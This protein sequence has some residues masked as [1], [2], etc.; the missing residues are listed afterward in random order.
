MMWPPNQRA[1][2]SASTDWVILTVGG[3]E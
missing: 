2:T 3:P 1:L